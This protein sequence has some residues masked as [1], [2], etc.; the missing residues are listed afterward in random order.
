MLNFCRSKEAVPLLL[1]EGGVENLRVSFGHHIVSRT[2]TGDGCCFFLSHDAS[3]SKH[4]KNVIKKKKNT[5]KSVSSPVAVDNASGSHADTQRLPD[6]EEK[7]VY[8]RIVAGW[9]SA[10]DV[11]H[12]R[13]VVDA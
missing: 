7:H 4:I 5:S 13:E 10:A 2:S 12:E 11:R 9:V 8:P 3:D 1:A 6:D